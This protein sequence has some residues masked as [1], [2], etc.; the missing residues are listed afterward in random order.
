LATLVPYQKRISLNALEDYDYSVLSDSQL[1]S[2][3]VDQ[4]MN[5]MKMLNKKS[6]S[7]I[8]DK[9]LEEVLG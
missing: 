8:P 9:L 3:K 6:S 1:L 5:I 7:P 4:F 2:K